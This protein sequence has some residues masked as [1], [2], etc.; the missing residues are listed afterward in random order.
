MP[1]EGIQRASGKAELTQYV[2]TVGCAVSVVN[3]KP[4]AYEGILLHFFFTS[5]ID[6]TDCQ[7]GNY[8]RGN[9]HLFFSKR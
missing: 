7:T 5:E 2:E 8:L 1:A 3:N 9:P 4:L 6:V